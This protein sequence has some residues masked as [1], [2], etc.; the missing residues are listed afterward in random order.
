MMHRFAKYAVGPA[1]GAA[2]AG[3][4]CLALAS[5]ACGANLAP[6]LN[7]D[8]A[9]VV[10]V[11]GATPTK[12]YV[13]DAIVRALASR[14]W[15]IEQETPDGITASV[16]T[17]GHSA[18]VHIQ[19]DDRAF[20]IHYVDSSPSLKYDGTAIHRRYNLWIDRLRAAIRAQLASPSAMPVAP[21]P[22]ATLAPTVPPP[23]AAPVTGAPGATPPPPPP[24]PPPPAAPGK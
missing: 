22:A 4:L 3:L 19:Y 14:N 15:Q 6:V 13:R 8:N 2:K 1:R 11:G 24:P 10:A 7:V 5:S 21:P 23:S 20:S 9:P 12:P 18:T 17:G 16:T